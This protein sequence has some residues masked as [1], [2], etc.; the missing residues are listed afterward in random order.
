[1]RLKAVGQLGVWA[2]EVKAA[3]FDPKQTPAYLR[4]STLLGGGDPLFGSGNSQVAA[5][6]SD[7]FD[8][9]LSRPHPTRMLWHS[10]SGLGHRKVRVRT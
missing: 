5:R 1:M 10:A 7:R 2:A 4:A 8:S 3:D 6:L 9:A